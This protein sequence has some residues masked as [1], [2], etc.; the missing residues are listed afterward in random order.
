[1]NINTSEKDLG[2]NTDEVKS[3]P[4]AGAKMNQW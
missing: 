4:S 2:N 3:F 1:M